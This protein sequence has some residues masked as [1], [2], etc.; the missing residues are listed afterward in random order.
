MTFATNPSVAEILRVPGLLFWN[1]TGFASEA[2]YGTKLGY[3]EDGVSFTPNLQAIP[4]T[5]EETGEE[6]IDLI[7]VGARPTVSVILQNYSTTV[8]A[9]CFP[10]GGGTLSASYPGTYL[11]GKDLANTSAVYA[12]LLF[13]PENSASYPCLLLQKAVPIMSS[14]W[15]M[16]FSHGKKMMYSIIFH[17]IVK[18]TASNGCFYIG[19]LSGATLV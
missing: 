19:P 14:E 16:E 5:E 10:G 9:R 1:P 12:P 8:L 6:I 15:S 4:C 2:Q 18:S 13:V 7:Y 3:C 11:K 17:G